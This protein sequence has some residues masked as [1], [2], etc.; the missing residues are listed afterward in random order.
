MKKGT[1]ITCPIC[2][3]PQIQSTKDLAAGGQMKDAEFVSLG[4]DMDGL[5]AGCY[6]CAA[7]FVREHPKTRAT[8]LHTA[9][10]GWVSLSKTP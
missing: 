2:D 3:A 7:S 6:K 10:N 4:F 1:I 9:E 8:Q 5:R